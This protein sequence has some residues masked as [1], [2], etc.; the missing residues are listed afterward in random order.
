MSA[1]TEQCEQFEVIVIGGGINGTSAAR[2]LSAA[3]YKILLVEKDDLASGASS[4]SS[5]ILHC[6]LRYFET[7][8]PVRTFASSPFKLKNAVSMARDAMSAR[9]ELV[10]LQPERCKPFTMCFPLYEKD[11]L[12]GWHLDIGFSLLKRLGATG[13]P[14]DYKRHKSGFDQIVP[15]AKD[16]RDRDQLKSIAT[17]REY[18]IDWPDRLCVDAALDAERVGADIRLFTHADIRGKR[19]NGS[20]Q[21]DLRSASGL[22][23]ACAPIIL[24]M[25]GTWIDDVVRPLSDEKNQRFVYGT[26]GSHILVRLPEYYSGYGVAALNRLGMPIYCLPFRDNLFHIGP[27]ETYFEGDACGVAA[28]DS[29]VDFLLDEINF[30][31]PGL[32]LSKHDIEFT[33]AGVRPLTFNPNNP[34]GDRVRQIHD[35]KSIGCPGIYAMTAGPVM[36]HMSAG[37]ELLELVK[38]NLPKRNGEASRGGMVR[39]GKTDL[40]SFRDY[41]AHEHARDLKGIFYTR[42]GIAWGQHIDRNTAAKAASE[43]ADLLGWEP[44]QVEREVDRFLTFQRNVH[45]S[46]AVEPS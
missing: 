35:L 40:S 2:E 13:L 24:N 42:S 28:D 36:S 22:S 39:V 33:W 8:R 11:E 6:G 30:L 16:L 43:I 12:R 17:Y 26:K 19:P 7:S 1:E 14:L 21:V 3:G 23:S 27:T 25:A 37:R 29:D 45:R 46:G 9:E 10:R 4:R 38:A 20:W 15:L 34:H 31:L 5:R 44:E 18:I 41:V 32:H